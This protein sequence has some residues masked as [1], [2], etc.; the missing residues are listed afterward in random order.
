VVG[1]P[2]DAVTAALR[3]AA[4]IGYRPRKVITFLESSSLASRLSSPLQAMVT[5]KTPRAYVCAG[6]QCGPPAD[7]PGMLAETLATFRVAA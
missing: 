7:D 4:R 2:R 3:R 5:G 1:D 6:P